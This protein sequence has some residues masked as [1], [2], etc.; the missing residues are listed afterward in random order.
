MEG[1]RIVM[2]QLK[3]MYN[4]LIKDGKIKKSEVKYDEIIETGSLINKLFMQCYLIFK[5]DL[6]YIKKIDAIYDLRDNDGNRIC[7]NKEVP[8][9]IVDHFNDKIVIFMDKIYKDAV[10][11]LKKSD[12]PKSKSNSKSNQ[13]AGGSPYEIEDMD[14]INTTGMGGDENDPGAYGD[15]IN[16]WLQRFI[17]SAGNESKSQQLMDVIDN[18]QE[19]NKSVFKFTG[20]SDLLDDASGENGDSSSIIKAISTAITMAPNLFM[21]MK[22]FV[23]LFT[24][25]PHTFETALCPFGPVICHM[26]IDMISWILTHGNIAA[27]PFLSAAP[28][29]TD[30]MIANLIPAAMAMSVPPF[31]PIAIAMVNLY[32]AAGTVPGIIIKRAF[33]HLLVHAGDLSLFFLAV[34]RKQYAPALVFALEAFPA[35]GS[36]LNAHKMGMHHALKWMWRLSAINRHIADGIRTTDLMTRVDTTDAGQFFKDVWGNR[37]CMYQMPMLKDYYEE[38][39]SE[40]DPE[41]K[42]ESKCGRC[43]GVKPVVFTKKFPNC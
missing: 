6:D 4:S 31:T 22:N 18:V 9:L 11:D 1:N 3:K 37:N 33:D 36:V 13:S 24:H 29:M 26:P 15:V 41:N 42:C 12:K 20:M 32:F 21:K 40:E 10:I 16:N 38:M 34:G 17:G 39:C 35:V 19:T 28:F 30:M 8:K 5:S 23:E 14:L 43:G 7:N 2:D 27:K 25:F